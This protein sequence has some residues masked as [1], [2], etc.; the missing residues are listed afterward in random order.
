MDVF[1]F[2]RASCLA[3]RVHIMF[4]VMSKGRGLIPLGQAFRRMFLNLALLFYDVSLAMVLAMSW[5]LCSRNYDATC[6]DVICTQALLIPHCHATLTPLCCIQGT[7]FCM[8]YTNGGNLICPIV[9]EH[10][11]CL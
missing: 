10:L 9:I 8:S 2:R 5:D 7:M 3:M 4:P 11:I 1:C 6:P